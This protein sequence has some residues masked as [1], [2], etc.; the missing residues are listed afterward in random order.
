M[1][2]MGIV[3]N[4]PLRKLFGYNSIGHILEQM[5]NTMFNPA[6]HVKSKASRKPKFHS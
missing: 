5:Y 2:R 6:T 1:K 3:R 4:K